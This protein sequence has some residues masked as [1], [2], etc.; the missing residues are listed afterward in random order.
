[1]SCFQIADKNKKQGGLLNWLSTGTGYV[2]HD[3]LLEA[4]P[5]VFASES[6]SE[7]SQG[8]RE[9][10]KRL[11]RRRK[12][13]SYYRDAALLGERCYLWP[14]ELC[15]NKTLWLAPSGIDIQYKENPYSQKRRC[16][17]QTLNLNS[18]QG[19]IQESGLRLG[20]REV[21]STLFT[22]SMISRRS[23]MEIA[24][25]AWSHNQLS[26]WWARLYVG[27]KKAIHS[28]INCQFPTY[29]SRGKSST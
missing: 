15:G 22:Q 17:L 2:R 8:S 6:P 19:F 20:G 14:V 25:K 4:P 9:G 26:S 29:G 27:C 28:N 18:C 10:L 13:Q 23:K 5:R 11:H 1:M 24:F 12:P 16:V 7:S 21:S 3:K